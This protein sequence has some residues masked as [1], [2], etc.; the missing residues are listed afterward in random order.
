MANIDFDKSSLYGNE[1]EAKCEAAAGDVET[2]GLRTAE[3][4]EKV[5]RRTHTIAVDSGVVP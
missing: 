3:D 4:L 1:D 2:R 5:S